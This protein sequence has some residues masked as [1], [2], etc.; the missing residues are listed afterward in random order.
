MVYLLVSDFR[1]HTYERTAPWEF[2]KIE[3]TMSIDRR[4]IKIL[5]SFRDY[6]NQIV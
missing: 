1:L 3:S 4:D 6:E 2:K 5:F